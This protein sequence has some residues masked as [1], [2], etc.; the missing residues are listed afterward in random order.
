MVFYVSGDYE[1]AVNIEP[2][3][4]EFMGRFRTELGRKSGGPDRVECAKRG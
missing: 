1:E 3:R 4:T 2:F